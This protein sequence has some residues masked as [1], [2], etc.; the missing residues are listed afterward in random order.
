LLNLTPQKITRHRLTIDGLLVLTLLFGFMSQASGTVQQSAKIDRAEH[1]HGIEL[2]REKK[3]VE[4]AKILRKAVKKNP[5]DNQSW[6][7][8]GLSLLH[9][10]KEMKEATKAFEMA[11]KL[12]PNFAAA[13]TG[14]S[15]SLLLRNK[16]SEA[17]REA[18]AALRIEPN[19]PDAHYVIGVVRLRAGAD[20]DALE[21]ANTAIKLNPEFPPGYLLKSQALVGFFGDVLVGQEKESSEERTTRFTE[22]A[23]ALEKYLLLDPTAKDEQVWTDQLESL[24]FYSHRTTKGIESVFSVKQVTTKARVLK[25]PE[26]SYTEEARRMQVTGV[27]VLR[28][29]FAA[30]GTVRNFLIVRGLPYGMTEA[31]IS[32]ARK[33]KFTPAAIDGRPVS[34]FIQLE[35][36][37]NLY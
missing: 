22:A 31:A 24:R 14:L 11:L 15:Y 35:Y 21:E 17:L 26:P 23:D 30:D 8:L 7:Y 10:P 36:H 5:S 1:I 16:S 13:H 2:Y 3:Y 19:I 37:F 20:E 25:K 32:A 12:Q 27:V 4:A 28:A 18:R 33:I 34:M 29:V 6:Y 9:Q